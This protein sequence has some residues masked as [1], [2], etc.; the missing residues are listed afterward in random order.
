MFDAPVEAVFVPGRGQRRGIAGASRPAFAPSAAE[1]I[2]DAESYWHAGGLHLTPNR[3]PF[4]TEQRILWPDEPRR[5]PS[6]SMWAAVCA[7][8]EASGGT[9]MVN[10]IGAAATI[11]RAHAHLT[12]ERLDFLPT[13]AVE[14]GPADLA[15]L[16]PEVELVQAALPLCLLGAR[17]GT[18][19]ARGHAIGTLALARLC[20]TWNVVGQDDTAWMLPRQIETPAPHFPFALGAAELWGRWC[21][22]D[23]KAFAAATGEAMER[24]LIAA[25]A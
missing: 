15:A 2:I 6:S 17:G 19:A 25:G 24:A 5:E 10:T 8:V 13:L 4:A 11:A 22:V 1:S 16:I 14:A 12:P 20:P 18:A 3:Y 21:Y 7:W 9:A 23:E